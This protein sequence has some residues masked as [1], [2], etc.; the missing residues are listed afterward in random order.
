MNTYLIALPAFPHNK[1]FCHQTILV[2]A[3][4]INDAKSLVRHLKPRC[5]IGDIKQVNY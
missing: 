2:K 5:T 4:G 3:K 1:G